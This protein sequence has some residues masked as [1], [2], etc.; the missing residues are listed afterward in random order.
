VLVNPGSYAGF[1]IDNKAVTVLGATVTGVDVTSVCRIRNLGPKREAALVQLNVTAQTV[2]FGDVLPG[3]ELSNNAG[4]VWLQSCTFKGGKKTGSFSIAASGHGLSATACAKVVARACTFTGRDV[5]FVA[6]EQPVTGGDGLRA[7]DSAIALFDCT[8]RGGR[9]SDESYPDGGRGG[10]GCNV[11][12]YGVVSS[13]SSLRGGTGG[14]GDYL[15]CTTAGTGG[16][17]LSVT[18]AQAQLLDTTL[19]AGSAGGFY[20]CYPGAPGQTIVSSNGVVNQ[21]PGTR[22]RL[23]GPARASDNS[24]IPLQL[25]GQPGDK[26]WI[27]VAR[28]PAFK[29]LPFYTAVTAVPWPFV[30]SVA[31]MGVTNSGG[32]LSFSLPVGDFT[33]TAPFRPYYLQAVVRATTGQPLLSSPLL[34]VVENH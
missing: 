4:H 12:G 30:M 33:E 27:L 2:S 22:R 14:G 19:T 15:G 3:L 20:T 1:T 11:T 26:V 7:L 13:G 10:D 21:Y 23:A 24:N 6:G 9:G 17:A 29:F 25:E 31:P 34:I 28:A 32:T 16:D 5:G 18:D 8:V